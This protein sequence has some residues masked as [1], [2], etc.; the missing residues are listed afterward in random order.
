MEISLTLLYIMFTTHPIKKKVVKKGSRRV[1]WDSV[2]NTS[3]LERTMFY[4]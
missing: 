1:H 2:V 4:G 3:S